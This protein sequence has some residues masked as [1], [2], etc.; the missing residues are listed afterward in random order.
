MSLRV[1]TN[2]RALLPRPVF[3]FAVGVSQFAGAIH[4]SIAEPADVLA[5]IGPTHGA[6]AVG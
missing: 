5:A 2:K 1:D 3:H 6:C 4:F